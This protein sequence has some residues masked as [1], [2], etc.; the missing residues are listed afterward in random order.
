M[1]LVWKQIA[2]KIYLHYSKL[3]NRDKKHVFDRTTT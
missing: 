3:D 2:K 1:I